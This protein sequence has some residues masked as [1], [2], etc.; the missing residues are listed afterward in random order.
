MVLIKVTNM[1]NI[2]KKLAKEILLLGNISPNKEFL[3]LSEKDLDNPELVAEDNALG[4]NVSFTLKWVT[5]PTEVQVT[6][7]NNENLG[8]SMTRLKSKSYNVNIE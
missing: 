8:A 5:F 1:E 2:L 4:G 7:N 3:F 6:I